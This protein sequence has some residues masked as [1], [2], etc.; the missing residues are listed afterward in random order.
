M[1]NNYNR[2]T[3]ETKT[4]GKKNG[5]PLDVN[6]LLIETRLSGRLAESSTAAG[7]ATCKVRPLAWLFVELA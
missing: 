6:D 1:R 7:V 3:E 5:K 4:P 2:A